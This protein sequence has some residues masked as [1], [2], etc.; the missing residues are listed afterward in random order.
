[1]N[2]LNDCHER[3]VKRMTV[4]CKYVIT[5]IIINQK[6]ITKMGPSE[7]KEPKKKRICYRMIKWFL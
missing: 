1:M 2:K 7:K 4:I 3:I 5:T 6:K